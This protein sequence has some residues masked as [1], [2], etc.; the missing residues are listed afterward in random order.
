MSLIP[1]SLFGRIFLMILS[2]MA[3]NLFLIRLLIMFLV[4]QPAAQQFAYISE[5]LTMLIEKTITYGNAANNQLLA[6]QLQQRTGLSIVWN[7]DTHWD[8]LPAVPFFTTWRDTLEQ[9]LHNVTSIRYQA[10]PQKFIW[11]LH[12]K[13]P[14]FSVGIPVHYLTTIPRM[15]LTG[16]FL[17]ICFSISAAYIIGRHL[18]RPL[19]ALADATTHL[20][21]DLHAISIPA[22]APE[23]IG[24]LAQALNQMS[25]DIDHLI[26]E[27]EFL[28]AGISHDLRT[29][30]TRLRLAVEML[31]DA[32][33]LVGG[34]KE[35]VEEINE[36]L[37]RFIELTRF[38]AEETEL[39]VVAEIT[40]LLEDVAH[41]YRR[42]HIQISLTAGKMPP[43]RYKPL[44]LRR[45]LYNLIDNS[46]KYGDGQIELIAQ[47][48]NGRI[49]LKVADHGSGFSKETLSFLQN[50][51]LNV[52]VM[53]RG[54]LGLPIV[55]RIADLHRAEL[56]LHNRAEGGAEVTVAF[57]SEEKG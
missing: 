40:P 34:M 20:G 28:L 2:M 16:L 24:V 31:P 53:G 23:E 49:W 48:L 32:D 5:S 57:T 33:E 54:G 8:N 52:H 7:V 22:S 38:N 56:T 50:A 6:E 14:L 27:Q 29:P 21:R 30:L 36:S 45:L 25:A 4:V 55:R 47:T 51:N 15:V 12:E 46:I 35:D 26:R 44:A 42:A 39:W 19:S 1:K 43:L 3:L 9:A 10:E 41:K 13:P 18:S 11:L 37:H 17:S